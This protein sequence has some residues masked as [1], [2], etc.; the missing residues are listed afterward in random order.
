MKRE[1]LVKTVTREQ[2][3]T[4][5]TAL[6]EAFPNNW[7]SYVSKLRYHYG[8]GFYSFS[9]MGMFVGVELNGYIHT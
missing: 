4:V 7:R 2:W 5:C 6:K 9:A 3:R 1:E 8:D